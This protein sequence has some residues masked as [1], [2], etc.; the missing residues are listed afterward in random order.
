VAD[1]IGNGAVIPV[2][3][4]ARTSGAGTPSAAKLVTASVAAGVGSAAASTASNTDG[5]SRAASSSDM[6]SGDLSIPG[7]RRQRERNGP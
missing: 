3:A 2:C 4:S 5:N 7:P 1:W 6:M